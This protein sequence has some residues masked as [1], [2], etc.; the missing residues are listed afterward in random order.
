MTRFD[1]EYHLHTVFLL[2]VIMPTVS[3]NICCSYPQFEA[4]TYSDEAYVFIDSGRLGTT[5]SYYN[6]TAHMVYD[7]TKNRTYANVTSVEVSPQLPQPL[8]SRYQ[9]INDYNNKT[10]Y[11]FH[12]NACL[13]YSI[14]AFE[15]LCVPDTAILLSTSYIGN[16]KTYLDTY[17]VTHLP[18]PTEYRESID[19]KSCLP[20]FMTFTLDSSVPDSGTMTSLVM[21]NVQPGI[22]NPAVFNPPQYCNTS[23]KEKPHQISR[24]IRQLLARHPLFASFMHI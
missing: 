14:G 20:V 8:V 15:P 18:D 9:L 7:F 13:K 6:V 24:S 2:C 23:P 19:R 11:M 16:N 3:G 1:H 10:Q 5:Y 4:D 22:S 12:G 21:S 17:L